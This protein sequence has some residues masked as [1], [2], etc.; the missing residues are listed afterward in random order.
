M[1]LEK[2]TD[3]HSKKKGVI[4]NKM[5]GSPKK[6]VEKVT[7]PIQKIIP[8]EIKP[9]LPFIASAFG[10]P[11]L[12]GSSFMT[13]AIANPF[14][15]NLVAKGITSAATQGIT[16]GKIDPKTVA[17]SVAPD[18]LAKG[19]GSFSE[20]FGTGAPPASLV[21]K[22]LA[23]RTPLESLAYGAEKGVE[24]LTDPSLLGQAKIIGA[25][26]SIEGASRLKELNEQAI[27]DYEAQLVKQGVTDKSTRRKQIYSIFSN[28][29]YEPDEINSM[30]DTYGYAGYAQ[31]GRVGFK[32]GGIGL[33]T[34]LDY[35]KEKEEEE[36]I[37]N[38]FKLS[39]LSS[40]LE[41]ILSGYK[42]AAGK[43][44]FDTPQPSRFIPGQFFNQGGAVTPPGMEMD[45]RR[46]GFIPIG[47]KEK[48]D[49]VNARVSKNEFV[50]TADAVRGAG[51]GDPRLG[52]KRMY[53]I[54]NKFEAMA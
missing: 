15:R 16:E 7:K 48:A 36:Q 25:Q 10:A 13:N 45:L 12:A 19:L 42:I 21:E 44:L 24:Y 53:E 3:D 43:P 14:V 5:G 54:M 50:M 8:K 34:L 6:I 22:G 20:T 1:S 28:A 41:G 9:A 35:L 47:S 11:Y 39:D 31:G 38:K 23:T 51:S 33:E 18:V 30:L 52:A 29:G 46:G 4:I 37:K 32:E 40:G 2:F 49:D 26:T 27:R 17:L